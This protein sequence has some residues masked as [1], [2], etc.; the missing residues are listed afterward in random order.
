VS[1][2]QSAGCVLHSQPDSAQLRKVIKRIGSLR[3]GDWFEFDEWERMLNSVRVRVAGSAPDD[4]RIFPGIFGPA[5]TARYYWLQDAKRRRLTPQ[6]A[7][8][9]FATGVDRAHSKVRDAEHATIASRSRAAESANQTG[10]RRGNE[11]VL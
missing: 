3:K 7:E 6:Q 8:Q 9:R 1:A 11:A 5:L 10:R 4:P 2:P